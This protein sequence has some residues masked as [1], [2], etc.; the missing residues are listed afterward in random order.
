MEDTI[1]AVEGGIMDDILRAEHVSYIYQG[2]YQK[3]KALSDVSCS[4]D[5][6]NFYAVVGRSGSGKTTL[7]SILAGLDRPTQGEIFYKGISYSELDVEQ[8]RM[9]KLSIVFQNFQLFPLL[10][11]EENIMYP[12]EISRN[13]TVGAKGKAGTLLEE[14][15]LSKN[16]RKK[17]PTMLSGGE[18]QRVAI[19]R[20]LA[21]GAK[22]ILADEP[23][24]N[25]DFENGEN[26]VRILKKLVKEENYCVIFVTH[27]MGIAEQADIVYHV[28]D[29][30]LI[31]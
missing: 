6:G 1:I 5:Y 16:L 26:I 31:K 22:I 17:Y 14:V 30:R 12:I 4:F 25:L 2:K 7:L 3:V 19:A 21:S 29:G 24:G 10:T 9:E 28:R 11:V 8:L 20:A 27:D 15:G 13:K 23:T 18:Q